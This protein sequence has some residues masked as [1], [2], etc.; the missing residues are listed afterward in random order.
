M[1]DS[2]N[3]CKTG[4]MISPRVESMAFV[5]LGLSLLLMLTTFY[6]LFLRSH[7]GLDITDEG[8]YLNWLAKPSMYDVSMSQFGFIYH[9]LYALFHGDIASLRQANMAV[10]FSLGWLLFIVFFRSVFNSGESKICWHSSPMITMAAIFALGSLFYLCAFGWLVTPSYNSLVFQALLIA[11]I[12]SLLAE[13]TTSFASIIGWI[14]IGVSGWLAFMAKPSSAAALGVASG[15][16][17]LFSGKLNV[18]LLLIAILT[19]AGFLLLSAWVIDGSIPV[20]IQRYKTSLEYMKLMGAYEHVFRIDSL[21][22]NDGQKKWFV[23][24]TLIIS[25]C[26]CLVATNKKYWLLLVCGFLLT[27]ILFAFALITGFVSFK[28]YALNFVVVQCLAFP[29]GALIG[30]FVVLGRK[31]FSNS[32][33]TL[34]LFFIALPYVMALGTTNNYWVQSQLA[35]VFWILAGLVILLPLIKTRMNWSI[36]LVFAVGVQ[37]MNI[38]MLQIAT[39]FPY[40]QSAQNGYDTKA[41]VGVARSTLIFPK[42]V[43]SFFSTMHSLVKQQN[44]KTNTPVIDL[45]GHSPGIL[46]SIGARAIGQPWIIGGYPGSERLTITLLG[47]VNCKDITRS[48]LLLEPEGRLAISPNILKQIGINIKKDYTLATDLTLPQALDVSSG[49]TSRKQYLYRPSRLPQDA[50]L[51]C[52]KMRDAN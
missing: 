49:T 27:L 3:Q 47:A 43:A 41:T 45:T 14:L 22:L 2:I 13:K 10:I 46:Y 32:Y 7:Y 30:T 4:K 35:A 23:L 25:I 42:E 21:L 44:F 6:W 5:V 15:F 28:P 37:F 51:A 20:F 26:T 34:A 31:C 19:A 16:Y 50:I 9:P 11:S 1:K 18:R 33:W 24:I 39:E 8:F 12:G 52:Q 36:L 38:V 29:L 17:L 40:R 48:W